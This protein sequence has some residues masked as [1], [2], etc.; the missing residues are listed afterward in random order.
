L[1]D[2]RSCFYTCRGYPNLGNRR[3]RRDRPGKRGSIGA[4]ATALRTSSSLTVRGATAADGAAVLRIWNDSFIFSGTGPRRA[5]YTRDVY[6]ALLSEASLIVA[7]RDA[8]AGTLTL[9]DPSRVPRSIAREGELEVILLA[10]AAY[11]RGRGI[12]RALLACAHGEAAR[13]RAE[14]LVLWMRPNQLEADGLYRSL[15][16]ERCPGRD[17]FDAGHG[18]RLV[19]RTRLR[20]GGR[21]PAAVHSRP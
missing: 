7:E 14:A 4:K 3:I 6:L 15:G 13:R 18:E 11:A 8:V 2:K 21:S 10:V 9:L 1:I 16:Y 19:Y 17:T 5:P 20:R 12:A